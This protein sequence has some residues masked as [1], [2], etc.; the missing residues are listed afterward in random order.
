MRYI[1]SQIFVLFLFFCILVTRE[2]CNFI[3]KETLAQVF[4]VNK[5]VY[6]TT[7]DGCF[8]NCY[9]EQSGKFSWGK[10]LHIVRSVDI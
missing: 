6:G 8:L 10:K 5:L 7:L 9:L 2:N 3:E 4:P 1:R